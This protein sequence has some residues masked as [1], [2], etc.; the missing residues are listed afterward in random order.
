MTKAAASPTGSSRT[1]KKV[2]A[3]MISSARSAPGGAVAATRATAATAGAINTAG[4]LQSRM[5]S[6]SVFG[7][8][9]PV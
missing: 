3:T 4:S 2:A 9:E 6:K 7:S 8:G 1:T 5:R